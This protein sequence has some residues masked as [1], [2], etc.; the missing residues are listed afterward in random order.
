MSQLLSL[1]LRAATMVKMI[2]PMIRHYKIEQV[3][4]NCCLCMKQNYRREYATI[5][6]IKIG[7]PTDKPAI[8]AVDLLLSSG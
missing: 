7:R 8:S 1:L 3:S 2:K 4:K 5:I 6:Q